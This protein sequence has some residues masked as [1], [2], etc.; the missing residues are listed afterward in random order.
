MKNTSYSII[1]ISII[2]V[3][4]ILLKFVEKDNSERDEW[5]ANYDKRVENLIESKNFT[6]AIAHGKIALKQA[7][8]RFGP[9][10]HLCACTNERLAQ[11]YLSLNKPDIALTHLYKAIEIYANYDGLRRHNINLFVKIGDVQSNLLQYTAGRKSYE[12]AM[13]MMNDWQYSQEEKKEILYKINAIKNMRMSPTPPYK[14]T[15]K[16]VKKG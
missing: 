8:K 3:C 11:A 2:A 14:G 4:M 12:K 15:A 13:K 9:E 6:D 10:D 5:L 1:T 7:E 16:S